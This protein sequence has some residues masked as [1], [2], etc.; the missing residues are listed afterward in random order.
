MKANDRHQQQLMRANSHKKVLKQ[1]KNDECKKL[2]G[3][4]NPSVYVLMD[5]HLHA[6]Q[7]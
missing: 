7:T 3:S 5:L 6:I 1:I 2:K 4:H